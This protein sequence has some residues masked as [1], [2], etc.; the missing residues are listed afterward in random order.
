MIE[1]VALTVKHGIT[2]FVL[3]CR[4]TRLILFLI[5]GKMIPLLGLLFI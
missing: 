4:R 3:E 1:S 2:G 5:F